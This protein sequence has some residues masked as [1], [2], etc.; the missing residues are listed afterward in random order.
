[1]D[2]KI[3]IRPTSNLSLQEPTSFTQNGNNNAQIN[4]ADKVQRIINFILPGDTGDN[5]NLLT[6]WVLDPSFYNLFVI[7]KE[8]FKGNYFIVPKEHALTESIAADIKFKYATLS[9]TAIS[10][11]RTYPAI[12]A[13]KNKG[14]GCTD[15]EHEAY[16]GAVCDVK[17]QE[18][19]IK[20]YHKCLAHLPQ[21]KLN[22]LACK[23]GIQKAASC[24]EFDH[25]HWTIKNIN[26]I[27]EFKNADINLDL[28]EE[29]KRIGIDIYSVT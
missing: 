2:N 21:Q 4:Y 25:T 10:K 17:I 20:I 18:N 26:I 28:I 19:G 6:Q 23:L 11:I 22:N 27:K 12:F 3:Q 15:A 9:S 29:L 13:N 24:N 16:F 14:L 5:S 7:G 8:D 1:M